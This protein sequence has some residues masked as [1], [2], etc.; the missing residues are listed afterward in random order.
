M[1]NSGP[2]KMRPKKCS[3]TPIRVRRISFFRLTAIMLLNVTTFLTAF[4]IVRE[5]AGTDDAAFRKL[6]VARS[7]SQRSKMRSGMS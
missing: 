5:K 4:S 1:W 7:F 3:L 2:S 6:R